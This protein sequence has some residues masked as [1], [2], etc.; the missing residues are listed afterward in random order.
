MRKILT[1]CLLLILSITFFNFKPILAAE[2]KPSQVIILV[3][4]YIGTKDLELAITPNLEKLVTQSGTGLMNVRAKNRYPSSAYMSISVGT[5]VSTINKAELSFNVDEPITNLPNVFEKSEPYWTAGELYTL[6][7]GSNPPPGSMVNLYVENIKKNSLVYN[8]SYEAGQIGKI[9]RNNNLKV[10]VLGNADTIDTCN[11]DIAILGMDENGV[12][13]QGDVSKNLVENDSSAAGGIKAN[14][15]ILLE[16]ID[17]YL[18]ISDLLII[19]LGDTTRVETSRLTTA[20]HIV[21]KQRKTA[22][23]RNDEFIGKLLEHINLNSTMLLII[24]PNPNKEMLSEAN[25]GLTPLLIYNPHYPDGGLVT[26]STTRRAGII[27]N[28]D[29]LP[30]IFSFLEADYIASGNPAKIISVENNSIS[31][32]NKQLE[33]FKNLRGARNSLHLI[34]IGLILASFAIGVWLNRQKNDKPKIL[35]VLINSILVIPILWMFISLTA[36][37]SLFTVILIT[38]VGSFS[39]GIILNLILSPLNTLFLTTGITSLLLAIDCFT[40]ARLMLISP[41][42]SDAIAGGRYYGV[43]NDFMGILLASSVI[44]I[45]ILV[46]RLRIPPYL[47]ALIGGSFLLIISMAIGHPKFGANVGGLI[48][49]LVT[50][51]IFI[52]LITN[53]KTNFKRLALLGVIAIIGVIGVA[54]LDFLFSAAPSHA[55]KAINSLLNGGYQV[56]YSIIRTKLGILANT[57]YTSNWTIVM[58]ISIAL[59]AYLWYKQKTQITLLAIKLP[60]LAISMRVL[61]ISAFTVFVV[62]DTGVIACALILTY[63]I[64]SL[65][66]AFNEV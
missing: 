2:A 56:F 27:T 1:C 7:T 61:L 14:H 54:Q 21:L 6:F 65:W 46:Y 63:I 11:R 28:A 39:L 8:P 51:G 49:S 20:D 16:K 64:T 66:I 45:T 4:D 35:M 57:V 29:I 32:V 60:D 48:T 50:V 10:T 5:R 55:G 18:P 24:S 3:M 53:H 30:T 23:E 41:L 58:L 25:M 43:G 47:K 26:S 38:L 59:L 31:A 12:I 36:Y 17:T 40:G 34:Y 52:M 22:I 13:L 15:T 9:A 44:F 37:Q 62:N 33:L 19:D 42:G